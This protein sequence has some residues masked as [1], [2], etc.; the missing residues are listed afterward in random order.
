MDKR[1]QHLPRPACP[2]N[3]R[4]SGVAPASPYAT[5]SSFAFLWFTLTSSFSLVNRR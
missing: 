5:V 4:N 3:P 1:S 2:Q